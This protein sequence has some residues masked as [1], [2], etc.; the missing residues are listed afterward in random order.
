MNHQKYQRKF[1]AG[2]HPRCPPNPAVRRAL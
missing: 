1:D 2:P